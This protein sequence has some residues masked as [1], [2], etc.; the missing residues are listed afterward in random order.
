MFASFSLRAMGGSG[1]PGLSSGGALW[2]PDLTQAALVARPLAEASLAAHE[3]ASSAL[4]LGETALLAPM[5]APGFAL[6]LAV[7]CLMLTSIRIGYRSV[8]VA[9]AQDD[10]PLARALRALPPVLYTL[11]LLNTWFKVQL[12]HAVLVHWAAS[13]GFTLALQLAMKN[14]A[15]AA[16][17]GLPS[18]AATAAAAAAAQ[19]QQQQQPGQAVAVPSSGA[20]SDDIR[21][22]V[23][24]SEDANVLV[25]LGAQQSAMQRYGDALYCLEKAVRL[26]PGH[27]RAHYAMGQVGAGP[28]AL[29]SLWAATAPMLPASGSHT[30]G[31]CSSPARTHPSGK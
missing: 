13:S 16:A 15:V 2:F 27:T 1:W 30:H 31:R 5:G 24:G 23:A 10:S 17:L 19:Q 3:L 26:E 9:A 22:A 4:L 6:P 14:L 8:G 28:Q 12:P 20:A 25:V 7:T 18:P 29:Q 21:S 11:T